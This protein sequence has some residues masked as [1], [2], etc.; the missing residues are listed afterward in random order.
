MAIAFAL[1]LQPILAQ[2]STEYNNQALVKYKARDYNGALIDFN[3]AI[4]LD[5][6]NEK[7]WHNRGLVK[8]SI[9][10][11]EG[12]IKDHSKAIELNPAYSNAFNDRALACAARTSRPCD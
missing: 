9:K 3:K 8:F 1:G 10:N 6:K 2:S 11:Y 12:A 5:A 4:E 7:A